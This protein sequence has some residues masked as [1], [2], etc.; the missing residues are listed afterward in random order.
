MIDI[1]LLAGLTLCVLS[2]LLA[3]V[4]VARTHAPRGA[5]IALVLGLVLA[6]AG[7]WL[8]QRPF[9]PAALQESWQRLAEGRITLSADPVTATAP[10]TAEPAAVVPAVSAP[11]APVATPT[12]AGGEMPAA[13]LADDSA[14][15][16][17]TSQ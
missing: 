14:S 11:V 16:T 1:L 4:S 6:F 9:G 7:A 15:A 3:I 10:G 13:E 2:V 17:R 5:A 12:G 8:D